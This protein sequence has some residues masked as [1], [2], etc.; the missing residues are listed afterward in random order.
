MKLKQ[1][2]MMLLMALMCQFATFAHGDADAIVG[3]WMVEEKDA[4]IEIYKCGEKYCGKIVWLAEP[5]DEVSGQPRTDANNPDASKRSQTI[6][7]M[8]MME[9]FTYDGEKYY[10]DGS[11]YDSREGKHYD[12]YVTLQDDGNL[13]LKGGYKVFGMMVGKSSTWTRAE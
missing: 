10:N 13:Y 6:L 4:K 9:N 2:F 8:E 1:P 11:I 12:G 5:N 3:T 7:G